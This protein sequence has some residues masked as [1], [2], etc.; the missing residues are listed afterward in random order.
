MTDRNT[1]N[2]SIEPADPE[3]KRWYCPQRLVHYNYPCDEF[4]DIYSLAIVF[5]EIA[6]GTGKIPYSEVDMYYLKKHVHQK[7]RNKLPNDIP[8]WASSYKTLVERM[9]SHEPD[10]RGRIK[11]IVKE[12]SMLMEK[13]EHSLTVRSII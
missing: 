2:I 13:K 5:W 12:L 6:M 3:H 4:S 11:S 7:N 9:W 1:T 10:H 8:S